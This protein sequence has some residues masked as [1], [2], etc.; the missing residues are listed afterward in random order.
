MSATGEFKVQQGA[1]AWQA[2]EFEVFKPLAD[3]LG[4]LAG[5]AAELAAEY[6]GMAQA[7]VAVTSALTALAAVAGSAALLNVMRGRG[8]AGG[9]STVG[10][11]GAGAAG[12]IVA[13]EQAAARA[14]TGGGSALMRSISKVGVAGPAVAGMGAY[15]AYQVAHD[16]TLT[17]AQ[18]TDQYIGLGARAGG[19]WAGMRAGATAGSYFGPWGVLIGGAAGGVA[20][21]YLGDGLAQYIQ[22]L[23]Q[24]AP[25]AAESQAAM[26]AAPN[27]AT[28]GMTPEQVREAIIAGNRE[29]KAEPQKIDLNVDVTVRGGEIVAEVNR[30][31]ER[32][33]RRH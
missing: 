27:A 18:K 4:N 15:Q 11:A 13:A 31:N 24:T 5:K 16:D 26:A 9:L 21:D 2:A 1:N 20:G 6:P 33:S 8:A 12:T 10:R 17:D 3:Q 32:E 30:I 28:L 14:A 23:R 22:H 25:T 19:A 29:T 7:T